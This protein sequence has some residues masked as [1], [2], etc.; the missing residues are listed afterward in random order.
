MA[1]NASVQIGAAATRGSSHNGRRRPLDSAAAAETTTGMG[2]ARMSPMQPIP[3]P[4]NGDHRKQ[5]ET[6]RSQQPTAPP[7][8]DIL[9]SYLK[10]AL[11]MSTSAL[12]GGHISPTDGLL[13]S[14]AQ[15]PRPYQP[16]LIMDQ[17][18]RMLAATQNT[19]TVSPQP[20]PTTSG[21]QLFVD[22]KLGDDNTLK[23]LSD[24]GK[25]LN[26][27]GWT[28]TVQRRTNPKDARRRAVPVVHGDVE[29]EAR[30]E[31][32]KT[33]RKAAEKKLYRSTNSAFSN[34][35]ESSDFAISDTPTVAKRVE[36]KKNN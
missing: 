1:T 20:M 24:V 18:D 35:T 13:T 32:R 9:P 26:F 6:K 12:V 23:A 5:P 28:T 34:R 31:F 36:L 16:V 27:W 8:D 3:T 17:F 11:M 33:C 21:A 7:E 19:A 30:E 29:A 25:R 2:S 10:T 22:V 14:T 4:T 15:P